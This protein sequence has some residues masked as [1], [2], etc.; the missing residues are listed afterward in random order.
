[1]KQIATH[2]YEWSQYQPEAR[3]DVNAHFVRAREGQPGALVNPVA[4][5]T[6]DREHIAE[7]GRV[8]GIVLT[9]ASVSDAA[10]VNECARAFG[11][12]VWVPQSAGDAAIAGL[13]GSS[14]LRR[15]SAGDELPGGLRAGH[16]GDASRTTLLHF[17]S[18]AILA[19]DLL[20]GVPAGALAL[21]PETADRAAAARSLR[22]L[23]TGYFERV[24]VARGASVVK[25]GMRAVQ[26]LLFRDDPHAFLMRA[27]EAV[28][29]YTRGG[30]PGYGRRG[31]EYGRVLG[32]QV[33]DFD[34]QEVTDGN[35]ST[36]VHKHHG[37]EEAFVVLSG[38]GEVHVHRL[39]A[40]ALE[41]IPIGPGDVIAFPP[42][43][44]IAHSFKA[45]GPEPLR[46]LAF[47]A[48]AALDEGVIISDYTVSG[49]RAIAANYT[50]GERYYVPAER[51]VPYYENEPLD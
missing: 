31:S 48:P 10:V 30:P 32:L 49:K 7:L 25:S 22:A 50:A 35:R 24:L 37:A 33:I 21:P 11:C 47:S 13:T 41:R 20:H 12:P 2:L 42:R 23:L 36:A 38:H 8:A 51:N 18:G 43:Y 17:A 14:D 4:L 15:Y 6:G 44:Q 1:M 5:H 28:V 16:V 45:V 34:L 40:T 46:F 26:D 27:G 29:G 9:S 3:L 19:G 39:G